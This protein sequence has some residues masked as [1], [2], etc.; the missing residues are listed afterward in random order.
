[1]YFVL[2][3]H[4]HIKISEAFTQRF[5]VK[6]VFLEISQNLHENT[7]VGFLTH[8]TSVLLFYYTPWKH[9][10]TFRFYDV[11]RGYRKATPGCNGL[12]KLQG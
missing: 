1:M 7:C 4:L 10:E 12:V 8:Y 9:R 5:S 11:F 3:L 2:E 6:K